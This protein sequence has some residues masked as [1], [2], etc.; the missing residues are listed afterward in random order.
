MIFKKANFL[1]SVCLLVCIVVH[2][3]NNSDSLKAKS[4]ST[5]LKAYKDVIT[6]SAQTQRGLI[7]IHF[8]NKRYF[9]EISHSLLERDMLLTGRISNAPALSVQKPG[10]AGDLINELEIKFSKGPDNVIFLKKL[11]Y[12]EVANDSSETG[13]FRAFKTSSS[14]PI[15]AAFPIRAINPDSTSYVIDVTD[16]IKGDNDITGFAPI[17]KK[18]YSLVN[19]QADKSYVVSV[20]SF[21]QNTEITTVKTYFNSIGQ[22]N[23]TY[24]LNS[25]FI[26]LSEQPLKPRYNDKRI[27]YFSTEVIDFDLNPQR[28]KDLV[29][30]ATRW[31]LEPKPQDIERYLKGGLV[32]PQKPIIFYIDPATPKRWVP[33]LIQGVNDWQVAFEKAGFKKAIYALEA[34]PNDPNWSIEDARHNVIVYKPSL[35]ENAAGLHVHDPRS[36]EIIES[37]ISWYHNV[38]ALLHDWYF[39]QASPIDPRAQ[40][41]EFDDTLMGELIRF[42]SSHEIG[43]TL[44]L[45]HNFGASS[46]VPVDSLRSRKWLEKHGHTPSIMDYARFN[47][48]A[49]PEDSVGIFGIF[50]HIGDYDKFAIEWGYRWFPPTVSREQE[51]KLLNQWIIDQKAKNRYLYF[52]YENDEANPK[53][54]SE[55]LGDNAMKASAYGIQNLKRIVPN[56]SKWTYNASS[57]YSDYGR[58]FKNLINQFQ[59]YMFHVS[60]NIGGRIAVNKTMAEPGPQLYFVSKE[61]Q[62]DAV[63]FLRDQLFTTPQWLLDADTRANSLVGGTLRTSLTLIQKR[64]LTSIMSSTNLLRLIRF[65]NDRPREA[66][67]VSELLTDLEKGIWTELTT[68]TEISLLRRELQKI[69]VQRLTELINYE[70]STNDRES[71]L[72]GP[73]ASLTDIPSVIKDHIQALIVEIGSSLPHY[74]DKASRI[75]LQDIR[76]RLI[77]TICPD[78]DL[79]K[80]QNNKL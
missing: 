1:S 26:L 6:P 25:S 27:G 43:H 39:V 51:E 33:Y 11:S 72:A 70:K 77:K 62:K 18:I 2:S 21:H 24:E 48:V 45:M 49:Q 15:V 35:T 34:P 12:R 61:M 47:Y 10:L 38:M 44:G 17:F 5:T 59:R 19:F 46:T 29:S 13:L 64:V 4:D 74:R 60:K 57:P 56:L 37:H 32:E 53:A 66:Y 41:M 30:M 54:Q 16:F 3:Q 75:H 9:F 65:E 28:G 36:G 23:V 14:Q 67:K 73:E 69:Y 58:L 80:F 68:Y 79:L 76:V 78:T 63:Q 52:G 40:K 50:P 7:T 71:G 31:R 20:R 22:E 8:A 42:V 55:D